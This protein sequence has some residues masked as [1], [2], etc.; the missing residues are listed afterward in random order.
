MPS[1]EAE[2]RKRSV[3]VINGKRPE[4]KKALQDAPHL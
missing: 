1:E 4:T 3:Y 2:K